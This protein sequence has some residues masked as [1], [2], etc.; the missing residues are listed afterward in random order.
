M[1]YINKYVNILKTLMANAQIKKLFQYGIGQGFN[2]IA[3]FIVIPYIILKCGEENYSLIL[4]GL[5]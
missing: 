4:D 5:N 1:I 2:V 3:P